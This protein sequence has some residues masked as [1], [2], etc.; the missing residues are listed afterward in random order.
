MRNARL[1]LNR[2]FARDGMLLIAVAITILSVAPAQVR[3]VL[4]PHKFEHIAAYLALGL[5][6]GL[7]YIPRLMAAVCGSLVFFCAMIEVLQIGIP[8][9]HARMEDFVLDLLSSQLGLG[10]AA[11]HLWLERRER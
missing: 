5:L 1:H 2:R 10:F 3:P 7:S 8:G 4:A 11:L 9:R 6:A